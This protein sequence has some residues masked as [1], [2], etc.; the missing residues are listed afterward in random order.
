[1][2]H[3]KL[4]ITVEEEVYKELKKT[5]GEG[6]ISSWINDIARDQ[7]KRKVLEKWMEEGYKAMA[8]DKEHEKEAH[9]WIEANVGDGLEEIHD[10]YS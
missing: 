8:A 10:E 3:K 2:P 9:E 1:M 4:T 6:K 5:I 7:L